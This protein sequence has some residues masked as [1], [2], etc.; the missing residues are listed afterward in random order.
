MR[1]AARQAAGTVVATLLLVTAARAGIS[2]QAK[3]I[4]DRWLDASGG[5][6]AFLA[7]TALHVKGKQV[8]EGM[9]GT[10]EYWS[11][12]PQRLLEIEHVGT[13][14][15]R[16]G[17]DGVAGWR[18]DL[19]SRK[20]APLEGK[21]LEAIRGEAWFRSEQWARDDQGGGRVVPGQHAFMNGRGLVALD[22]T[23]PV[24]PPKSLWFDAETG[25]LVRI[26]HN[27]D[28][29][30]WNE[31]L[32]GWKLL[33]GRRRWTVSMVGD[34]VRFAAGFVRQNV[35]S[36]RIETP[37]DP[38]VFSAPASTGRSVTWLRTRGV[39]RLPFRYRRGHVWVRA[40]LNGAPAGDFILD[41]GCTMTAVDR[42]H[43]RAVGLTLEGSMVAQGVG[44]YDTGGWAQVKSVRIT[45]ADGDGVDV[46]DLKVGVL[47]LTDDMNRREWDDVAG[48]IGYDV[49]SRFVVDFD[50]DRRVVTLHDPATF[51]YTGKG[52]AVPFT[53]HACIPTVEVTLNGTCTGRFIVDVGNA[54]PMA[55]HADQVDACRLFAGIR[56]D[57]Q[58]WVGGIGGAFPETVCR[59]DSVQV[60][61]F[62]WPQPIAGLT[63]HHYGGAGSKDIQGNLG[64][65]ILD[66]FRCTFDYARGQLWL[67][68]GARYGQRERFSRSGL[69]FTRWSGR[70]WIAAVVR[71][72]PAA[73]AG[74]KVRDVLKA[75]NGRAVERWTPEELDALFR[76][77]AVGTVVTVT[78][79]R[80]LVDQDLELT[81]ADVL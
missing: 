60:G 72:S 11:A 19:T 21:D 50:F 73:D 15:Y 12:G 8:A 4:V 16:A 33:A 25:L 36:V 30:H 9:R 27:R 24:G 76:D 26:T 7:D 28:Q 45:G 41:T 79:E 69:Y 54:T 66:R 61:P 6:E 37:S 5:R 71:H 31:N 78:V 65:S 38:A 51:R 52:L 75:V 81:L 67:E 47:E 10:F 40:S 32:S 35:D 29:H 1:S 57:V 43:A 17:T 18:T 46:P 22:V 3:A 77:G 23:P 34:S 44:G 13:L 48:L 14:R 2:P 55:V 56:K 39:A 64:T 53:L 80:E 70:V 20:V 59:L 68:P 74:L 58:H 42:E 62:R 63:L 49:L